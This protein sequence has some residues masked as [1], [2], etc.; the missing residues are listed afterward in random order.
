MKIYILKID[1]Q[2]TTWTAR[3]LLNEVNRDRSETWARYT[4]KDLDDDFEGVIGWLD[5]SI[6]VLT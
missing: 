6:E 3:Q 2:Q 4:L 5:E 1:G